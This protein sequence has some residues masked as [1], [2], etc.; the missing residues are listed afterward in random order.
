LTSWLAILARSKKRY[1]AREANGSFMDNF[2]VENSENYRNALESIVLRDYSI[3]F[4]KNERWVLTV[5]RAEVTIARHSIMH[6]IFLATTTVS[7]HGG[8]ATQCHEQNN[9][10]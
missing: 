3:K 9:N 10:A 1:S 2:R 5:S 8:N 4:V 6:S 7:I